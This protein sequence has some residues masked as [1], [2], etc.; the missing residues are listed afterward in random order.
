M[1]LAFRSKC[2]QG[3]QSTKLIS[4]R[5][6][7]RVAG[8][9]VR[10]LYAYSAFSDFLLNSYHPIQNK[11]SSAVQLKHLPTGI[12]VKCQAT[13]SR[14]QNRKTARTLLAEKLEHIEKGSESRIAM[15]I[16]AKAKRA[17]NKRKKAKRKYGST[18][19]VRDAASPVGGTDTEVEAS[20]SN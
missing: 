13:R 18:D 17:A 12:V 7:S 19:R 5:P 14:A 15:R 10:R 1:P 16:D 20:G 8:P 3:Q 11:T 9:G 4:K 2:R 6:F